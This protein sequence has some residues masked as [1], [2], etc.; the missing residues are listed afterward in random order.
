MNDLLNQLAFIK[1]DN[2]LLIQASFEM[3]L[4]TYNALDT[5]VNSILSTG[6]VTKSGFQ[7]EV[8]DVSLSNKE[9]DLIKLIKNVIKIKGGVSGYGD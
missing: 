9:V 8:I 6:Q 5:Q 7:Q 4:V 2:E 1:E 3:A